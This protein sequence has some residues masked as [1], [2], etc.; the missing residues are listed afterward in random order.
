MRFMTAASID[1][2]VF[3]SALGRILRESSATAIPFTGTASE[4]IHNGRRRT[5]KV[6]SNPAKRIAEFPIDLNTAAIFKNQVL[7]SLPFR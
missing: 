7:M 2:I 6:F 3:L 1:L 4:L 5:V